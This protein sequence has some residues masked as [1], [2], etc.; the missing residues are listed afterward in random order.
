MED[1]SERKTEKKPIFVIGSARSGTS[2]ISKAI[3]LGAGIY[4]Y[5]EG[6]LLPIVA[7]LVKEIEKEYEKKKHI[8]DKKGYMIAHTNQKEIEE[9]IINVFKDVCEG[10]YKDEVWIDKTPDLGMIAATPYIL[11]AWPQS[12][13][14]FAKRRGVECIISRTRKFQNVSF[15]NHCKFWKQCMEEWL[16]VR[17]SLK[18]HYIEID[19]REISLNP[20]KVAKEIGNLLK[21]EEE[22]IK[23]IKEVFVNQRPEFTGGTEKTEAIEIKETG[24]TDEQIEIF[25]KHCGE[26]SE[27]FGYS[28]TS[29]YYM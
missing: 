24:W 13:L 29:D 14:I 2:I 4:G 22:K 17:E 12:K 26:V 25:R 8:L 1:R 16:K 6:H 19:Q 7:V 28:E 27:K 23:R 5:N 21:I 15:E 10:I 9:R 11:R 3:K 18:G 20:E